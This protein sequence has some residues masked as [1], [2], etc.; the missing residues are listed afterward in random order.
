M[1]SADFELKGSG[2]FIEGDVFPKF[3]D[4]WCLAVADFF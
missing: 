2:K 1:E 4:Q 3:D